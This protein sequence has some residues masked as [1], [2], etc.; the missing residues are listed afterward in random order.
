MGSSASFSWTK[1]SL[2]GNLPEVLVIE[3]NEQSSLMQKWLSLYISKAYL[4][5]TKENLEVMFGI[6]E[7][8][9]LFLA[10][11]ESWVSIW[12]QIVI[13]KMKVFLLVRFRRYSSDASSSS[14]LEMSDNKWPLVVYVVS[15]GACFE[16][17]VTMQPDL[18][19]HHCSTF[20][21][22]PFWFPQSKIRKSKWHLSGNWNNT[23]S[24][25]KNYLELSNKR[26]NFHSFFNPFFLVSR[27][28]P[29]PQ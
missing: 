19:R 24:L 15:L 14:P 16:N 3:D 4:L 6:L 12:C 21:K 26:N 18:S 10:L 17:S 27:Y 8:F 20:L 29:V 2:F 1:G 25:P 13:T 28:V 23:K 22:Y 9:S 5:K 11:R 7:G